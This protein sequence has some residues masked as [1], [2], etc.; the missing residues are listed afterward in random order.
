MDT[1]VKVIADHH[2][3]DAEDEGRAMAQI[4]HD[5]APGA[6]LLF[7]TAYNGDLDFA[8]Q[9]L[10]LRD[11]GATVIWR[12]GRG[13]NGAVADGVDQLEADGFGQVID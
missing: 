7:A 4:V 5:L 10:A 8:D 11:A 1:P 12:P 13:L 6:Q 3:P 9:I 2:G